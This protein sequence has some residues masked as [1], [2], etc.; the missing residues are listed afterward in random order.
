MLIKVHDLKIG[1][2]R[3][4]DVPWEQ[5]EQGRIEMHI[6]PERID[7]LEIEPDGLPG[8][9]RLHIGT[10][11]AILS[12]ADA[13]RVIATVNQTAAA[14]AQA[15]KYMTTELLSM[16]R[17]ET[18]NSRSPFWRCG[19]Q[20]G[21]TVNVFKHDDPLKD[22]FNLFDAAGYAPE[23]MAMSYG[24]TITWTRDSI[25]VE[26]LQ[27]GSFWNVVRVLARHE[28]A[29][30]DEP[31]PDDDEILDDGRTDDDDPEED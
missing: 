14:P 19:T 28:G 29:L 31:E 30:P 7:F 25:T 17:D 2:H 27:N 12:I 18:K 15:P 11:R 4:S 23:M 6:N 10:R 3:Y 1:T 13:Q 22:N 26:L 21:F 16:T 24:D 9:A 5:F 8:Y 20:A